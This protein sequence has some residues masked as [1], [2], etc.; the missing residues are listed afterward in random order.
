MS[1]NKTDNK[2]EQNASGEVLKFPNKN[3][4]S[5]LSSANE[6]LNLAETVIEIEWARNQNSK[7]K[8]VFKVSSLNSMQS[9]HNLKIKKENSE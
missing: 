1:S 5:K 8:K 7:E 9:I 4:I 2:C 3:P 6:F